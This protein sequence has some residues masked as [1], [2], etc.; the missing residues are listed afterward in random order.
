[1]RDHYQMPEAPYDRG[2]RLHAEECTGES[3]S[4]P[5]LS[6]WAMPPRKDR[7]FWAVD[8]NGETSFTDPKED[9]ARAVAASLK[10]S[11]YQVVVRYVHLTEADMA[12]EDAATRERRWLE[13]I[14][15]PGGAYRVV[16]RRRK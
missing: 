5:D 15:K 4:W 13:Q 9:R 1:M 14:Y 11:G 16:R 12:I 7:I 3:S 2:A 10:K 8:V 6:S